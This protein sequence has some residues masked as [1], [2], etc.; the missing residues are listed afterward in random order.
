MKSDF[1]V[2]LTQLAAERNLPR[3]TVLS[4]IEA[5]LVSAYRKDS[6]MGGQDI[7]VKL[8]P[9]TGEVSVYIVKTVAE[10]IED[11]QL[12]M[13]LE[14]ARGFQ[15]GA[16]IGDVIP[17]EELPHSAGRIAAQTAK[18]VV[19]QR[20]RE[21]ERELVFEE[22]ADK[23]GEVFQVTIQRIEPSQMIVE[24]GRVEAILPLSEQSSSE[25]V[26]IGQ[27]FKVLLK[28]VGRSF[29]GPELIVSRSDQALLRR[30]FEMEVPEIYNGAVEIMAIAR[31]AGARSKVAVFARQDGVDPVG[32]CV[33]LRGIRIQ[34]IVNELHGERIDVVEWHR[35]PRVYIANAL[36][37]SQVLRVDIDE[38]SRSAIAVVPD[39]QLSL[40][41]GKEGQNARLAAK[42]TG[43]KV[44]ISSHLEAATQPQVVPKLE[45]VA[46]SVEEQPVG[47]E[48]VMELEAAEAPTVGEVIEAEP[49]AADEL[50]AEDM[51]EAED[52]VVETAATVEPDQQPEAPS[53]DELL[54]EL[55]AAESAVDDAT[56][57]IQQ[58]GVPEELLPTDEELGL[59]FEDE[60]QEPVPVLGAAR[61]TDLSEDVWSLRRQGSDSELGQ[62]R[63]A[64][65]IAGLRGGVTASRVRRRGPTE[66]QDRSRR[67]KRRGGTK[68][69]TRR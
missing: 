35:D 64:E 15:S 1:L 17:V 27:K 6:I 33:G 67:K 30:L 56:E 5:A 43:W 51:T 26:R 40:A 18:Q 11:P 13:T 25:W 3:D 7:S 49:V 61:I 39:R 63:F 8:D 37:P 42:L 59:V 44:D 68:R 55:E 10:E 47:T 31:E 38:A 14:E 65:D 53:D 16:Q 29:K 23:E 57:D 69:R 62:I 66:G 9:G 21:A 52:A 12:Q 50:A 48:D 58:F 24:M 32:S 34:N 19:M 60:T 46:P 45:A 36:S 22:Y 54:A 2:A 28:T 20:L 41:I 4:A